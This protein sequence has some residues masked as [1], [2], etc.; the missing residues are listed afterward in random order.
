MDTLSVKQRGERMSLIRAKN[1][2]PEMIVRRLLH[3]EG[4]RYRLHGYEL[5]GRPDIV[6]RSRR[7]VVFIHGCFWHRHPNPSCK[8]VRLPKSRR[9]FWEPKLEGNRLRDGRVIEALRQ[10]GWDSLV[11]WECELRQEEQLRN[12]LIAF[13]EDDRN[14]LAGD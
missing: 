12:R 6:F 7:K 11:V 4:Y 8:L 3:R 9:E 1:T 5:P 13:L 2:R 10:G 14:G